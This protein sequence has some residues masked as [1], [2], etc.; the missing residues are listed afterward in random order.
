MSMKLVATPEALLH[1]N[2]QS[3]MFLPGPVIIPTEG[4]PHPLTQEVAPVTLGHEFCGRISKA[5]VNSGLKVG[6]AVMVD[7]RLYCHSCSRRNASNT[8]VCHTWGFLGISGRGGGLADR[9]AVPAAMCYAL[10][11]N[12]DLSVAALI[13]PPAV[14]AR[15]M[16]NSGLKD[17]S[18]KVVLILG[19]GPIGLAVNVVLRTKGA[20]KVYFSEPTE[21]RRKFNKEIAEGVFDPKREKGGRE[22]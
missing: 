13:E 18:E 7:P 22:V 14:A 16:K 1:P 10:P 8:H 2:Y 12:V 21:K 5:S 17:F 19:G 15:A 20:K 6:Q 3:L 9:I 4:R 11:E